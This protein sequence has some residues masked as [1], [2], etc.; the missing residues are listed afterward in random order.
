M[1]T[2]KKIILSAALLPGFILIANAAANAY[3]FSL[4]V[5]GP[6]TVVRGYSTYLTIEAELL[7][8]DRDYVYYSVSGLPENATVTY[9]W[10]DEYCCQGN[11]AWAPDNTLLEISIPE[12]AAPGA[13]SILL[14]ADSGGIIKTASHTLQVETVPPML[15]RV[16]VTTVPPIPQLE[17]WEDNMTTKGGNLCDEAQIANSGMWEGN[18]WYYDGIR[19]YYQIADY[20]GDESWETCSEYVKQVY[21]PYV[22]DNNGRI[23]G[24][25]LFPHGLYQ[26]FLRTEEN[27]SRDAA[28]LLSQNSAFAS[29]GGGVDPGLVRETAYLIHSYRIA[30]LLG[31]SEHPKYQR[32]IAFGL[33]HIDQWFVAKTENY[34]QPFMV[35]LLSEALIQYHEQ[36]LDPRIPSAIKTAM[37][38]IWEWAWVPADKSFFYESTGN[39]AVGSPDLNLLIAPA[40]AWL[41]KMTGDPV[42]QTRGDL[43]FEGGV[44][45]AWIDRG[46]QFSQNYRWSFD[47]VTWRQN[48][49]SDSIVGDVN[50]DG[51]VNILDMQLCAN[52]GLGVTNDNSIQQRADVNMDGVVNGDDL[53]DLVDMLLGS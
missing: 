29:K 24:W 16:A 19:V 27:D 12:N 30:Q 44:E 32:A 2:C 23:Q 25:R 3:D 28:V 35:G 14:S 47:Y 46:K 5:S 11:R 45:G 8:G 21:R 18:I 51:L 7:E 53:L 1:N 39:T 22:I 13:Y 40:F 17:R 36:T 20:T 49:N 6:R 43:I 38:G 26:D 42:Y 41:Y 33:S 15:S 4:G 31:E 34:M 48:P 50:A 37:D 52:A 10:L 9:P